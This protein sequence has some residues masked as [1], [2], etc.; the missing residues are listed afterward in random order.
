MDTEWACTNNVTMCALTQ[1]I[2]V[3]N[4]NGMPNEGSAICE[5]AD[6]ILQYNGHTECTQFVITQLDM[7]CIILGFTWLH[8]HKPEVNWQTKDSEVCMSCCPACC[9]TC[10]LN[11]KCEHREQHVVTVQICTCWSG[12]FPVLI[13]EVEVEVN[14]TCE[15]M[16]NLRGI[17]R[18][19]PKK[20][21]C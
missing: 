14:Y 3:Y 19:P 21:D 6:V 1:K 15:G 18:L 16:R 10:R 17:P 12:G 2:P 13:E 8:E 7:Q 4:V 20:S 9:D 11:A 5:I